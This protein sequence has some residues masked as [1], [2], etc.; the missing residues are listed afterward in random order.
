MIVVDECNFVGVDAYLEVMLPVAQETNAI[1]IGLTT[2][3]GEDNPT[4]QFFDTKDETGQTIFR[5]I[6]IGQPCD[7]CKEK[8]VL[9]HHKENATGAGVS[10]RKRRQFM[11]FYAGQMHVAMREYQGTPGEAGIPL[12]R[13]ESLE[14]LGQR[15]PYPVSIAATF[16]VLSIDPAQGGKCDWGVC[17]CYYDVPANL[18]VIIHLDAVKLESVTPDHMKNQLYLTLFSIRSRHRLFQNIPIVV[19]CEAEPKVIGT[20]IAWC[21]QALESEGHFKN[22]FSMY[23]KGPSG[24]P[25]VP[26]TN[27]NTQQMV[28]HTQLLL[29]NDQVA[30]SDHF[31]TLTPCAHDDPEAHIKRM[32]F[33][34]V[35]NFKRR[36]IPTNR[37]DGKTMWRMDGKAGNQD[38]DLAVAYIMNVYWYIVVVMS[39]T[40]KYDHVTNGSRRCICPGN[41]SKLSRAEKRAR[42]YA[43]GS[44]IPV[45]PAEEHATL[46]RANIT[47]QQSHDQQIAPLF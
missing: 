17:A 41:R 11:N 26:K 7:S 23:E 12:F 1:M 15:R 38:D 27:L 32:L 25:G 29:D 47:S 14:A 18:Q 35:N 28:A 10:R 33:M 34:Q 30:F 5:H 40:Q 16:I 45:T 13:K 8:K 24:D 20:Q 4:S 36:E 2:P 21:I 46:V 37:L 9:C 19:A 3:L 39:V 22:V 31:K 43:F 44:D 6:R 42:N